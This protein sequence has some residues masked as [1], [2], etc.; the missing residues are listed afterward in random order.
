MAGKAQVN[1]VDAV[2]GSTDS[3][4]TTGTGTSVFSFS[5]VTEETTGK[6]KYDGSDRPMPK[7]WTNGYAPEG[8]E[9]TYF[10]LAT[11]WRVT[12]WGDLAERMSKIL[13]KGAVVSLLNVQMGGTAEGGKLNPR[14][15]VPDSGEPRANYEV[16]ARDVVIAKYPAE[17]PDDA[18]FNQDQGD[19]D[20]LPF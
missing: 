10:S 6:K 19:D 20:A 18:D 4:R 11:W 9:S 15:W 2:V 13:A 16:T 12:L 7:G 17:A 1:L 5:V 3:L 14:V 8:K